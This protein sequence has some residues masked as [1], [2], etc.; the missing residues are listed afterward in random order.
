M[1]QVR[2]CELNNKDDRVD[3]QE[4]DRKGHPWP[5]TRLAHVIAIFKH[6]SKN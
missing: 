4:R 6:G 1:P 3:D 5:I 2:D